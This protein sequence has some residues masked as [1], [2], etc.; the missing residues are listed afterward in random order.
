M[1]F[2]TLISRAMLEEDLEKDLES[3]DDEPDASESQDKRKTHWS[4][5]SLGF[6]SNVCENLGNYNNV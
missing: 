2:K 4:T 6:S 5:V 1:S 3:E